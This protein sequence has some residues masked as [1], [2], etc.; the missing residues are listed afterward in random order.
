[1]YNVGFGDCFVLYNARKKE[2]LLTD[3]GTKSYNGKN[4]VYNEIENCFY[5]IGQFISD[6]KYKQAL[7]THFDMDHYNG[8]KRMAENDIKFDK[9]YLPP[10]IIQYRK[11]KSIIIDIA[12][13]LF[14]FSNYR[15]NYYYLGLRIFNHLK[16]ILQLTD[17]SNIKYLRRDNTFTIGNRE[18]I[19]LWP[20][21]NIS[22]NVDKLDEKLKIID[23]ILNK[24]CG[25][26]L[27]YYQKQKKGII[28]LYGEMITEEGKLNIN[29]YNI[30][31]NKIE[32]KLTELKKTFK[33]KRMNGDEFKRFDLK[34]LHLINNLFS[35]V[36]HSKKN[37]IP[38]NIIMTGDISKQIIEKYL[39]KDLY[40]KYRILKIP[41]HG[42]SAYFT[43]KLPYNCISLISNGK[44]CNRS[45]KIANE[46]YRN[47][48]I[49]YKYCSA[50]I[51]NCI[52]VNLGQ[53]C[54]NG[55]CSNDPYIDIKF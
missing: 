4:Y 32:R 15:S 28:E 14:I 37:Y 55:N 39:I 9:I 5:N 46:Y 34:N 19:V 53:K 24:K 51:N 7:I 26:K 16:D 6:F 38:Q 1:M 45:N 47:E 30:I 20:P 10:I 22:N 11:R 31:Q 54:C 44:I 36:Y 13:F 12:L 33:D 50:G 41:H 8:F 29:N 3:C 52:T 18:F 25:D 40:K 27:E 21:S 35:I 48:K 23:E 43:N 2:C 49:C 42:T 17:I